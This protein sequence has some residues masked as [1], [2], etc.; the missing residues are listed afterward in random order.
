MPFKDPWLYLIEDSAEEHST[1]QSHHHLVVDDVELVAEDEGIAVVD[2]HVLL[3]LVWPSSQEDTSPEMQQHLSPTE[4]LLLDQVEEQQLLPVL[5]PELGQK[6]MWSWRLQE[7]EQAP[8]RL[9]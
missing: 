5:L 6:M 8:P 3:G 4:H 7:L 9:G 1:R 2:Q